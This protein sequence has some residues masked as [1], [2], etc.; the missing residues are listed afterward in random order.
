MLHYITLNCT[1]EYKNALSCTILNICYLYSGQGVIEE[2]QQSQQ[3]P[4][5]ALLRR[6][7][8]TGGGVPDGQAM[9]NKHTYEHILKPFQMTAQCALA[10]RNALYPGE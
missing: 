2:Q 3:Q 4:H 6:P 8:H 1:T 7:R 9:K 10:T 5:P